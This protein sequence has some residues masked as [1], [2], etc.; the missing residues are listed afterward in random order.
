MVGYRKPIPCQSAKTYYS[1]FTA[2]SCG[3]IGHTAS[4]FYVP[5]CNAQDYF[6]GNLLLKCYYLAFIPKDS[7]NGLLKS[8]CVIL[9]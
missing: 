3:F 6:H 2:I 7:Q 1:A 5:H 4:H 8:Q 9:N